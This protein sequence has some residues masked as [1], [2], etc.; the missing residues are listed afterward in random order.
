[1][2][3]HVGTWNIAP[4]HLQQ[5]SVFALQLY[6]QSRFC[7]RRFQSRWWNNSKGSAEK[8]RRCKTY[9]PTNVRSSYGIRANQPDMIRSRKVQLWRMFQ[10]RLT[11]PSG[12]TSVKRSRSATGW[13]QSRGGGWISGR[14]GNCIFLIK[15]LQ[16]FQQP[17]L[18]IR[19]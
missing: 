1:M 18:H 4:S 11:V 7:E 15:T 5:P 16:N 10:S 13:R 9:R 19:C 17:T 6:R 12:R 2:D 14:Q 8:P 3:G